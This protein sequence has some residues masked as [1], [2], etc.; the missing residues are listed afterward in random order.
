M[1]ILRAGVGGII[2]FY[3]ALAS[4]A[5]TRISVFNSVERVTRVWP[6]KPR[7]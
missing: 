7:L 5:T 2:A 1:G 4:S 6:R 3:S